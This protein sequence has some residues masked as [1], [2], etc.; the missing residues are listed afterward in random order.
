M[1]PAETGGAP[2]DLP[3][4]ISYLMEQLK[5]LTEQWKGPSGPIATMARFCQMCPHRA[6]AVAAAP[7]S[8]RGITVPVTIKAREAEEGKR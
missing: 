6:K 1:A 5:Q 3:K 7:F 4:E 2:R 8:A